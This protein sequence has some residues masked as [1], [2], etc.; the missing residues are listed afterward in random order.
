MQTNQMMTASNA[1]ESFSNTVHQILARITETQM[2][3][4]C[5]AAT[6]VAD[7]IERGGLLYAFGSG[8]SQ[9]VANEFYFRAGGLAPCDV[10]KERTFGKAERLAGYAALLLDAYPVTANDALVVISN[11]GRNPLPVEM[12]ETARARGLKVIG[13]TSLTHSR[14]VAP[15][16]EGGRRLFEVCDVVIDNCGVQGDAVVDMGEGI[17]VGATSTLAGVFI[18]QSIVCLAAGELRRRGVR[19]PVYLSMNLDEGDQR[20]RAMIESLRLRIRGL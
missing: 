11:S 1:A 20:N 7:T 14:S 16:L 15:R 19:P 6:V 18:A 2:A 3:H 17:L 10:I 5:Q 13:I 4:M 12:A 8:H 9:S